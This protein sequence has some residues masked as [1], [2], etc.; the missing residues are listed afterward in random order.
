M[1]A[2]QTERE[3]KKTAWVRFKRHAGSTIN[4]TNSQN[5]INIQCVF[6]IPLWQQQNSLDN[7]NHLSF[8]MSTSSEDA[9]AAATGLFMLGVT[10]FALSDSVSFLSL[11]NGFFAN[12][13]DVVWTKIPPFSFITPPAEKCVIGDENTPE[14]VLRAKAA[15]RNHTEN[16]VMLGAFYLVYAWSGADSSTCRSLIYVSAGMRIIYGPLYILKLAPWRTISYLAASC[17]GVYVGFV[18]ITNVLKN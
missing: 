3:I 9:K 13:E 18:G 16:A 17:T 2:S 8:T 5:I 4:T 1:T 15:H 7:V 12:K 11:V 10:S 6:C 14:V